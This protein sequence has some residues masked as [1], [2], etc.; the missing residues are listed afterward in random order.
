MQSVKSDK[1]RLIGNAF[2]SR[3]GQ[4]SLVVSRSKVDQMTQIAEV[5]VVVFAYQ[6]SVEQR[7]LLPPTVSLVPTA[8]AKKTATL[9]HY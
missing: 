7:F 5:S 1:T 9:D 4:L 2:F 3:L 8:L 6:A